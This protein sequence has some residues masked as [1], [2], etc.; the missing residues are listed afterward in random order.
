MS[1][2][3][4][5]W[6]H[7]ASNIRCVRETDF[8]RVTAELDAALVRVDELREDFNELSEQSERR[9]RQSSE[10][11]DRMGD[12][13]IQNGKLQDRLTESHQREARLQDMVTAADERADV[14]EGLL[15]EAESD[16]VSGSLILRIRAAL[17]PAEGRGDGL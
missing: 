7:E 14:L 4:R 11:E 8:D 1:E 2:V 6:S 16:G 12:L 3:Q 5:F 10:F 17:K 9:G 15:R 13:Q